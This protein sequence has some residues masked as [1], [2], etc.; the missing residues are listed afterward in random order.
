MHIAH[1]S[2]LTRRAH[3]RGSWMWLRRRGGGS[4]M[5]HLPTPRGTQF[6]CLPSSGLRC[7]VRVWICFSC[8]YWSVSCVPD[9]GFEVD[10]QASEKQKQRRVVMSFFR[11]GKGRT[12][13]KTRPGL[14][15]TPRR[16]Y[17]TLIPRPNVSNPT[18]YR[19]GIASS[20]TGASQTPSEAP[21]KKKHTVRESLSKTLAMRIAA[22][23]LLALLAVGHAAGEL[24][25]VERERNARGRW[26]EK[27]RKGERAKDLARSV[28]AA[29][30]FRSVGTTRKKKRLGLRVSPTAPAPRF[31]S[32]T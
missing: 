19:F 23:L 32:W 31:P 17:I 3:L 24:R 22:S 25:A 15:C 9:V 4:R 16:C 8:V 26:E 20:A 2:L 6:P 5:A 11:G 28:A 13:K 7:C 10:T 12:P 1:L 21:R 27:G 29:F 30:F 18:D 14:S